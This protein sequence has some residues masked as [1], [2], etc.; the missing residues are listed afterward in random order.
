MSFALVVLWLVASSYALFGLLFLGRPTAMAKTVEIEASSKT[1]RTE[2][3]AMYGGLELGIAAFLGF[4][5]LEPALLGVGLVA[6]SML[7]GGISVGRLT[8]IAMAGE[9]SRLMLILT[10]VEAVGAAL[11]VWAWSTL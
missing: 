2:I 6:S 1:A 9:T 11:A 4:C 3:R 7:L 10:A 5:A 8:G